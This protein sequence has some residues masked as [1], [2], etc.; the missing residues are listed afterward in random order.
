MVD[1]WKPWFLP[2]IHP[3]LRGGRDGACPL[4]QPIAQAPVR[5]ED[6][7]VQCMKL[8]RSELP[9]NDAV[10][11]FN[12]PRPFLLLLWVPILHNRDAFVTN[13]FSGRVSCVML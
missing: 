11:R 6:S 7:A 13:F 3:M 12:A 5:R 9:A 2:S 4:C 10:R 1:G 8:Y